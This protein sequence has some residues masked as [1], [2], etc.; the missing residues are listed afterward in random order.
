MIAAAAAELRDED[1]VFVGIGI[2]STACNLALRTH[3]PR[4]QLIYESGTIGTRPATIPLSIGDPVLV[5][6]T[7]M[8]APM[9]DVF[10]LF[11]QGGRIDVGFLGAAQVDRAANINT[12]VIGGY[13]EPAVRL[14]GSGGASEI[15]MHAK[16]VLVVARLD[17]RAFPE[18]VDFVTSSGARVTRVITDRCILDRVGGE[19]VLSALAPG[20]SV[21]EVRDGVGWPLRIADD[22]ARMSEPTDIQR[23][24]LRELRR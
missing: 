8:C 5:T 1:V 2:P 14:P 18:R 10:Q 15:A 13:A 16:R 11:L 19:L 7:A 20:A 4:L 21:E 17:R 22:L 9:A 6:D 23:A 24:T 3:A 12:T